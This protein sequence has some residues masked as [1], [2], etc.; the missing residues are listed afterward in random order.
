MAGTPES[1]VRGRRTSASALLLIGTLLA[2]VLHGTGAAHAPETHAPGAAASRQGPLSPPRPGSAGIGDPY[3]PQDGNGGYDVETYD[4]QVRYQFQRRRVSGTTVV[5]LV[6][7]A[8]LSSVNLDLLLPVSSVRLGG[9]P[10]PFSHHGHEL[11]ITPPQVLR[12][13]HRVAVAVTYAGRPDRFTYD[14]R[15]GWLA[16]DREVLTQ[17]EPHM[18]A[19]WFPSNDHPRDKARMAIS[20]TVP[21]GR[22]VIANGWPSGTTSRDGLVTHHWRA[23]EPMAP[24]L[25]F[26]AAG[27][28]TVRRGVTDRLPWITAVSQ[29]MGRREQGSAATL[30]RSTPALTSWLQEQLGPY[31]FGST[32]GVVTSLRSAIALENQTRPTYGRSGATELVVHELAHQWFGDSVSVDSW[33]DIWLNEGFAQFMEVRYASTHGGQSAEGWLR[34]MYRS[35]LAGQ[36]DFSIGRPGRHNV[37]ARQVYDRGAMTLQAL[38]NVV[39]ERAFWRILR[40]WTIIHRGASAS[41]SDFRRLAARIS[42]RDLDDFFDAWLLRPVRP[43]DSTRYGLGER[44]AEHAGERVSGAGDQHVQSSVEGD[45]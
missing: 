1:R 12:A 21:A 39:G 43:A 30:M 16:N 18:A 36:W 7:N 13:G 24:Y 6:P 22:Q 40:R 42:G 45:G 32:G 10:M 34:Q 14:G 29:D 26:F 23:R 44:G 37:F 38:S 31:P 3:W 11:T 19:W 20:V 17:G 4:I 33:A 25:A 41:I 8:D 9:R 27:R 2:L 35:G 5:S 28:F 15:R